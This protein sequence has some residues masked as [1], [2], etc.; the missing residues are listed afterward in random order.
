MLCNFNDVTEEYLRDSI[1]VL[2][3]ALFF[4]MRKLTIFCKIKTKEKEGTGFTFN[5]VFKTAYVQEICTEFPCL[6]KKA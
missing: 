3:H 6:H 5:P 2:S 1:I 4:F